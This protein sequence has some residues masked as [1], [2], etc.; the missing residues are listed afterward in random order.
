MLSDPYSTGISYFIDAIFFFPGIHAIKLL[1]LV[2]TRSIF[3]LL[4]NQIWLSIRVNKS[5]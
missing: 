3:I 2:I 1:N 5:Y 4:M